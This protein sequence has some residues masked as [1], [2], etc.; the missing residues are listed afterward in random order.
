MGKAAWRGVGNQVYNGTKDMAASAVWSCKQTTVSRA[1]PRVLCD[2]K[3][4]SN[5]SSETGSSLS[6]SPRFARPVLRLDGDGRSEKCGTMHSSKP[7]GF[8][9]IFARG[10]HAMSGL[11]SQRMDGLADSLDSGWSRCHQVVV[12]RV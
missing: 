4:A 5:G 12:D 9:Y 11:G 10:K 3:R 2:V 6:L 7:N 1:P 8:L